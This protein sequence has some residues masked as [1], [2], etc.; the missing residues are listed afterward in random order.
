MYKTAIAFLSH[1]VQ[2]LVGETDIKR[3]LTVTTELENKNSDYFMR[4]F[5]RLK[6][7]TQVKCLTQGLEHSGP[8]RND[9]YSC[10]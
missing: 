6:E 8:S 1:T 2:N 3:A 5:R 7:V 4:I 9:N 10:C